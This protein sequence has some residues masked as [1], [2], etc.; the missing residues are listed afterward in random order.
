MFRLGGEFLAQ[1]LVKAVPADAADRTG[2]RQ[3]GMGAGIVGQAGANLCKR[4]GVAEFQRIASG[5]ADPRRSQR[6]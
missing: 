2:Q 4:P 1:S 3:P 6:L 5:R